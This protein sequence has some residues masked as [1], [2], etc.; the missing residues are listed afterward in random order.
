MNDEQ[1]ATKMNQKPVKT[2]KATDGL[3]NNLLL[4][5]A[6]SSVTMGQSARLDVGT[7]A[8][9]E[10]SQVLSS[11][12]AWILNTSCHWLTIAILVCFAGGVISF[13]VYKNWGDL[14]FELQSM[15]RVNQWG[16]VA[17]LSWLFTTLIHYGVMSGFSPNSQFY[18][19]HFVGQLT[20]TL[21]IAWYF[22]Q[23]FLAK[24]KFTW[25]NADLK[26]RQT[27]DTAT[28]VKS[29]MMEFLRD[30]EIRMKGSLSN[31]MQ[32]RTDAVLNYIKVEIWWKF[33]WLAC[34]AAE[35][36]GKK[37][38]GWPSSWAGDTLPSS[39]TML[40]RHPHTF[41]VCWW[42]HPCMR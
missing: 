8:E 11:V 37:K 2:N 27:K 35:W 39:P 30:M 4:T 21:T 16:V 14:S 42:R 29:E 12:L 9:G 40:C 7:T 41:Q 15:N 24:F 5:I 22:K 26:Q 17:L 3:C 38:R 13:Q 33:G 36:G 23:W 18:G 10:F 20:L 6:A 25:R 28:L 32:L 1:Q 19:P 31:E 34:R